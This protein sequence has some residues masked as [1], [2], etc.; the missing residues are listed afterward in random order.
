MPLSKINR[1]VAFLLLSVTL[2]AARPATAQDSWALCSG[3]IAAAEHLLSLPAGL[4]GAIARVESGRWHDERQEI[5][6][7]PW[8][9]MAKGRGRFLPNKGAALREVRD[10]RARGIGNIDVGCMQVNLGY[11][12]AAFDDLEQAFD[13]A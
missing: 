6:A 8:T 2:T 9:V 3:H 10:L 5:I 11:H 13:P 12:G 1:T 4:L 7:W